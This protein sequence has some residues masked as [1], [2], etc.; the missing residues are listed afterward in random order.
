[1]CDVEGYLKSKYKGNP[2]KAE[3]LLALYN[4][5][6]SWNLKDTNFDS[7]FTSED[8]FDSCLWEMLLARYL[9]SLGLDI[10][11][12]D[13]GPDFKICYGDKTIW[14]EAICPAPKGLPED[15]LNR[16]EYGV[17]NVPHEEILLRWTAA[18]K[19]KKEKHKC[20]LEKGIVSCD[21]PY[22][23]AVSGCRLADSIDHYDISQFPFAVASVYPAGALELTIGGDLVEIVDAKL[24]YRPSVYNHNKSEVPT[25]NFCNSDYRYVSAVL[26]TQAGADTA[27][28]ENIPYA[29][30]HNFQ[31]ANKLP[32]G[33]FKYKEYGREYIF[34]KEDGGFI[35]KII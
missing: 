20:W 25:D 34:E 1:M 15:W 28:T 5:Y 18:L 9:K 21:D 33:I 22:V 35:P 16:R 17:Y 12:S 10:T 14:V 23:I 13:T 8:H 11:S 3:C 2:A 7:K 29:L 31:A 19:E 27:Y 6:D 32:I 30:A 24:G 4:L 26:G